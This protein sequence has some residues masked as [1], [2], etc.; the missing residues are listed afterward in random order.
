MPDPSD[1]RAE[2]AAF[3]IKSILLLDDDVEFVEA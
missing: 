1:Q 3:E 2:P